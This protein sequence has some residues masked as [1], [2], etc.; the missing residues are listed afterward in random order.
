MIGNIIWF[1][2]GGV[3]VALLWV[4][5]GV[6][7]AVTIIGMPWARSCF[8]IAKVAVLPFGKQ[9]TPVNQVIDEDHL[10]LGSLG[11]LGNVFWTVLAGFW[12]AIFHTVSAIILAIT[13]LGIPFAL[14]HVKLARAA[15]APNDVRVVSF[16][17]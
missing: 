4:I 10:T 14:Q 1:L 16:Y 17:K 9:F 2:L 6:L 5:V 11:I 15:L 7:A 12:L 13:I 3:E 8:M